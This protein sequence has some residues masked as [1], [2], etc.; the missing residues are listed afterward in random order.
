MSDNINLQFAQA[1]VLEFGTK[2]P[3]EAVV[4]EVKPELSEE[5]KSIWEM[6]T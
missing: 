3:V 1:P 6:L 4:E 5:E 2:E